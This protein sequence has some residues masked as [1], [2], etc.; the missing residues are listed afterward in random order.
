MVVCLHDV[1]GFAINIVT[2]TIGAISIGIGVD[3]ATHFTMRFREELRR[4]GV[5]HTALRVTGAGTG[6]ALL[7]SAGSSVVGFVILAFAPMPLFAAYGL[8]TAIMIGMAL[9]SS[10]IVLPSL[11][12]LATKDQPQPSSTVSA[13]STDHPRRST[14]SPIS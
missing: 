11:L 12:M 7:A 14:K 5:R 10:L 3:F 1:F 4:H 13:F 8:L 9:A 2:A 6:G